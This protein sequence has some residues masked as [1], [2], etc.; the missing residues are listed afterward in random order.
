MMLKYLNYNA[1]SFIF[2]PP[3][4]QALDITALSHNLRRS[5][6]LQTLYD[7][8]QRHPKPEEYLLY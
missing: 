2:S 4:F 8:T 7:Y 1:H 3:T 6:E 5:Y